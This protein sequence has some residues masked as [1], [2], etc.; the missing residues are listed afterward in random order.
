MGQ[1]IHS[2][3]KAKIRGISPLRFSGL[4]ARA[5]LE[6]GKPPSFFH[7]IQHVT[8]EALVWYKQTFIVD[9]SIVHLLFVAHTLFSHRGSQRGREVFNESE[10]MYPKAAIKANKISFVFDKH[11]CTA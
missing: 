2:R 10:P 6:Q 7:L 4:N 9:S 11:P 3:G 5:F 1:A 8:S